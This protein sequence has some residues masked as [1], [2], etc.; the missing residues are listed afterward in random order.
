MDQR[1]FMQHGHP[2]QQPSRTSRYTSGTRNSSHDPQHLV[3]E[4]QHAVL[5]VIPQTQR[6][7]RRQQVFPLGTREDVEQDDYQSPLAGMF[8]RAWDRYR[9][10]E[11]VRQAAQA[12]NPQAT[13]FNPLGLGHEYGILRNPPLNTSSSRQRSGFHAAL[14]DTNGLTMDHIAQLPDPSGHYPTAFFRGPPGT[15]QDMHN[16]MTSTSMSQ[17][18]FE[19]RPTHPSTRFRETTDD[20]SVLESLHQLDIAQ[21]DG[22]D[23]FDGVGPNAIDL[24]SR[25]PPLKAEELKVD[26]SCKICGEQRI[27]TLVEPC[28][29]FAM[30]HW[31]AQAWRE[32]YV[33]RRNDNPAGHEVYRCPV[34]R[35]KIKGTKRVHLM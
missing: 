15:D 33:R 20:V 35:Q 21:T 5:P 19:S 34:C 28:N 22:I 23:D 18:R 1:P 26:V 6:D 9:T 2:A 30:C 24:Q 3:N 17:S 8:T 29:H 31:C 12:L 16:A 4:N 7:H 14:Y 13:S 11:E 27:D 10:A 32:E 25:P